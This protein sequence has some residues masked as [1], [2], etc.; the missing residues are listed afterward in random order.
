MTIAGRSTT[1]DCHLILPKDA[2]GRD[3]NHPNIYAKY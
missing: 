2:R 1:A 3:I